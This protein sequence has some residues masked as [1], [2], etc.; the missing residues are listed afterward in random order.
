VQGSLPALPFKRGEFQMALCSHFL[1]LYS[2]QFDLDF[3]LGSVLALCGVAEDVRIFPLTELG[4]R[5]RLLG[6]SASDV[7]QAAV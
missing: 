3:H 2:E 6:S 4:S 7:T 5:R 1:F